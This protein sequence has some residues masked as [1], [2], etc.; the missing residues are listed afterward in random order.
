MAQMVPSS[1]VSTYGTDSSYHMPDSGVTAANL[2]GRLI[3][4]NQDRRIAQFFQ[5]A[6]ITA[7]RFP[8]RNIRLVYAPIT[9]ARVMNMKLKEQNLNNSRNIHSLHAPV[10][11]VE[12]STHSDIS[13]TLVNQTEK[14]S[15]WGICPSWDSLTRNLD[16]VPDLLMI[17]ANLFMG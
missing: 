13:R 10:R 1:Q 9:R 2:H 17:I 3:D 12:R 16:R 11:N 14:E 8:D 5:A 4:P 6:Q 7:E 15:G